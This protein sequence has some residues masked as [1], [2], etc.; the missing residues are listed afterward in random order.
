[1]NYFDFSGTLSDKNNILRK[2]KD[3]RNYISLLLRQNDNNS[4]FITIYGNQPQYNNRINVRFKDGSAHT[5]NYED[6]NNPEV[7]GNIPNYYKYTIA[8]NGKTYEYLLK[9]EFI[10]KFND[11][12]TNFPNDT[13]Y[14]F[15]GEYRINYS[16]GKAYNNFE[17]KHVKIDNLIRPEF[18]MGLELFYDYRGLDESD[19]ANKFILNAY[20]EQYSYAAREKVFY[21]IQVQFVT[22]RFD[23]KKQTDIEIIRYRKQNLNPPKELGYVKARW[24]SQ[25]VRGAQLIL[26]PLET[27]PKAIQFEI[28]NAGRDI[29]DYYQ[30]IVGEAEE[31]IVL[32]RPNN[33]LNKNGSIYVPLNISNKEFEN[34]IVKENKLIQQDTN[35]ID[36]I[37]KQDAITN[38]LN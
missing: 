28:K 30:K 1:M 18:K 15:T 13:I 24:E 3:N 12:A 2:T 22:N 38:P 16:N 33:T 37:A 27:L 8:C 31:F 29:K 23:F 9:D 6:R 4:A 19:K 7:L 10:S 34:K 25:Y 21:P 32:T 26:P 14:D 11:I 17:I 20:I 5:I 35:T 36:K